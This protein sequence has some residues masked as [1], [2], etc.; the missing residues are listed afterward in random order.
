[1]QR[2]WLLYLWRPFLSLIHLTRMWKGHLAWNWTCS[3][4]TA[5]VARIFLGMRGN[6]YHSHSKSHKDTGVI[7]NMHEDMSSKIQTEKK[8]LSVHFY[9]E[10]WFGREC[11]NSIITSGQDREAANILFPGSAFITVSI[12]ISDSVKRRCTKFILD[13]KLDRSTES[14]SWSR[15]FAA[16]IQSLKHNKRHAPEKASAFPGLGP[17][18]PTHG[19]YI[20]IA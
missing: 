2:I 14:F 9:R 19:L 7:L 13:R 5:P 12:S 15:Y 6:S 10:Q 20:W 18:F 11:V 8:Y 3:L 16:G 17:A 1:M 4:T